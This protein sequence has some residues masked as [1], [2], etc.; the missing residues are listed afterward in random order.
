MLLCKISKST[1]IQMASYISTSPKNK[2]D[3]EY[4]SKYLSFHFLATNTYT[5][6]LI[7]IASETDEHPL[8]PIWF[9]IWTVSI[10]KGILLY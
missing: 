4:R 9:I 2:L 3:S 5:N 10:I 1:A 6:I 8:L 7:F